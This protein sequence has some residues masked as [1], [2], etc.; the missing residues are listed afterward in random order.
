MAITRCGEPQRREFEVGPL[1]FPGLHPSLWVL[2]GAILSQSPAADALETSL[3]LWNL[4]EGGTVS[5][6]IVVITAH[7]MGAQM[8]AFWRVPGRSDALLR[9]G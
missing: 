3:G 9:W 7:G 5:M 8:K 1:A 4:L 2:F 6:F